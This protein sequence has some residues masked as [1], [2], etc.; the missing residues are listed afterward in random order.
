MCG[1]VGD[2]NFCA[3]SR[4]YKL[5]DARARAPINRILTTT[6]GTRVPA[7]TKGLLKRA[8]ASNRAYRVRLSDVKTR[9]YIFRN[10]TPA[11]LASP[12][13]TACVTVL[14]IANAFFRWNGSILTVNQ[15]PI[16]LRR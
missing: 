3:S 9:C 6:G 10:G 2:I 13:L 4:A 1:G 15:R 8:R 11:R 7:M 14:I 5:A 12:R 16:R